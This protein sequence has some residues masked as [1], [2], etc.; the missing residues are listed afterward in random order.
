MAEA[1]VE[2]LDPFDRCK[3]SHTAFQCREVAEIDSTHRPLNLIR[4]DKL[5]GV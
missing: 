1:E 2:L 5:S 3:R 4:Q